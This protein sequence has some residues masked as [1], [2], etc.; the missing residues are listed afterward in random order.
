MK[1][2]VDFGFTGQECWFWPLLSIVNVDHA[3]HFPSAPLVDNFSHREIE[4]FLSEAACM[5]DFNHPNVIRLLG[6]SGRCQSEAGRGLPGAGG[7]QSEAGRGFAGPLNAEEEK[8]KFW[9]REVY[10]K[11]HNPGF[12][13]PP[14]AESKNVFVFSGC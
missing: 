7:C 11:N 1:P 2:G 14:K 3:L 5:K 10:I 8:E 9:C 13:L 12:V 4:E 6:T